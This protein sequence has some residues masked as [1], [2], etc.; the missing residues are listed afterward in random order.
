MLLFLF[1]KKYIVFLLIVLS[2]SKETYYLY[3]NLRKMKS[4]A[5]D[6]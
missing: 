3:R 6:H 5:N 1:C 2:Q 4:L